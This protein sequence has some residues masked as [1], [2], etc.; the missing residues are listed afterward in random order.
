MSIQWRNTLLVIAVLVVFMSVVV[1]VAIIRSPSASCPPDWSDVERVPVENGRHGLGADGPGMIGLSAL[2][3][4]MPHPAVPFG[5]SDQ[6]H[7]LTAVVTVTSNE[8]ELQRTAVDCIWIT[9]GSSVWA[10]KPDL[11]PIQTSSGASWRLAIA[12][13]GPEWP[14]GDPIHA[15]AW[16]RFTGHRYIFDFGTFPLTRGG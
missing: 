4:Y 2:L 1:A 11:Y 9:H 15:E 10:R 12:N 14:T 13:D 16:V 7:P 8:A 6:R 3:D 5:R